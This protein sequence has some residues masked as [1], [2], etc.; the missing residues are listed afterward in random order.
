MNV[1]MFYN[2]QQ[3]NADT[4]GRARNPRGERL[5]GG[6]KARVGLLFQ[7]HP[8][9]TLSE[10]L[11]DLPGAQRRDGFSARTNLSDDPSRARPIAARRKFRS[12]PGLVPR[13]PRL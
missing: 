7:V 1:T 5:R 10:R 9:R 2:P 3:G 8:L 4:Q 12:A 6:R 11:S 13:L